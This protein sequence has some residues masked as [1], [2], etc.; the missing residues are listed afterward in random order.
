[1]SVVAFLGA[2]LHA[3]ASAVSA[4]GHVLDARSHGVLRAPVG[5]RSA[6]IDSPSCHVGA[7]AL[8]GPPT[9]FAEVDSPE[10]HESPSATIPVIGE[11]RKQR[12]A[13]FHNRTYTD[14]AREKLWSSY[15]LIVDSSRRFYEDY[16]GA[17][18]R[19]TDVL[20]YGSGLASEAFFLA[21]R[22]ARSVTGI[23]ISS[24]AVERDNQRARAKGYERVTFVVMDAE[25]M[26][27]EPESF[28]LICGTA[29]LH[30]L[31]LE[32]A[33]SELARVLRPGGRAIFIEPLGHNPLINLY[34]RRTPHLRTPDE[35]PLLTE[36][37][38][39]ASRYFRSVRAR[40]A[41]LSS[42]AA[43]P[44]RRLRFFANLVGAFDDLDR[45]LFRFVPALRRYAWQVVLE[46]SGP[47][48]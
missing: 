32:R 26:D 34:R 9:R 25:T 31:D 44:F 22:G 30:H 18:C 42:L 46:L 14:E 40:F 15:Y 36:D 6:S 11:L 17:R 47:R 35:H 2:A 8:G 1:M 13:E 41:H 12:E 45:T 38:E 10:P 3:T 43:V 33:Y 28:D 37:L 19:D 16:L 48:R 27:F 21:D 39:L 24:V 29:I 4:C 20:E 5:E 23:D 7:G